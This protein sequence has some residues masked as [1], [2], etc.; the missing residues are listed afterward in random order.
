MKNNRQSHRQLARWVCRW[1]TSQPTGQGFKKMTF[2]W[3]VFHLLEISNLFSLTW[4]L[5]LATE[6]FAV[7]GGS[8][9]GVHEGS[10]HEVPHRWAWAHLLLWSGWVDGPPSS[11]GIHA[12][13]SIIASSSQNQGD[14]ICVISPNN[15][16]MGEKDHLCHPCHQWVLH[17]L[18][19]AAPSEA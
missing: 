7:C 9:T 17:G 8:Y 5:K 18:Q 10:L 16:K 6:G 4:I 19:I 3:P 14:I 15:M 2:G 13:G 11:E 1:L 12:I